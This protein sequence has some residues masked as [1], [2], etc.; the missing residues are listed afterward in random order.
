MPLHRLFTLYFKAMKIKTEEIEKY[1][2]ILIIVVG[3]IV[4]HVVTKFNWAL[5]TALII[6]LLG[7]FSEFMALIIN[8][9]WLKIGVLLSYIVPNIIL[10]IIFYAFL[11]PI[12]FLSRVF[13][14]KNPL[15]I[16]NSQKSIFKVRNADFTPDTFEN[17]W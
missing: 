15:N 7:S 3:M 5:Y 14:E 8:N 12:A 9:V 13:G 10:T 17:P 4:I 2:T 11:T 6:G 16:K 1:K